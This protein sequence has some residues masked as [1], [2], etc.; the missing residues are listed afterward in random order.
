MVRIVDPDK[1]TEDTSI[2]SLVIPSNIDE[3]IGME[4]TKMLMSS[5][6][7]NA[8][9]RNE[10]LDHIIIIGPPGTGK[11]VLAQLIADKRMVEGGRSLAVI[12]GA[13]GDLVREAQS[14]KTSFIFIDELHMFNRPA[15]KLFSDLPHYLDL[16]RVKL[17]S[18]PF[19]FTII[20]ATTEP[21]E[22]PEPV[23]DR[24]GYKIYTD[25]YQNKEISK[26]ISQSAS[27]ISLPIKAQASYSLALRSRGIPRI[28]NRLLRRVRDYYDEVDLKKV[29]HVM[30]ELGVDKFGLDEL[31]RRYLTVLYKHGKPVGLSNLSGEIN[32]DQDYLQLRLEPYLVRAGFIERTSRGREITRSGKQSLRS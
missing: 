2:K 31:D 14:E 15:Y 1:V 11:S 10:P 25:Y 18:R 13:L 22:I 23:L 12:P 29:N 32:L 8:L 19:S 16:S 4:K 26:I 3:F 7:A 24:F 27:K 5:A 21:G 9:R 20:S 30:S 28:A 17:G 6:K